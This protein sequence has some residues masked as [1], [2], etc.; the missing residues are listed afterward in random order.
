MQIS[1][2]D[3]PTATDL[4]ALENLLR[5]SVEHGASVGFILPVESPQIR[6]YWQGVANEV[7]DGSCVLLALIDEGMLAG[8]VQ[9]S[10]CMK[11]NG[12]HRAELQK[13]LV[14]SL[15][16]RRGFGRALMAAA[17]SAAKSAGRS[18]MVLDTESHRAGQRLYTSVGY[19]VVGEIPN[20]ALGTNGGFSPTTFMYKEI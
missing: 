20:Y 6:A 1:R 10:L 4:A 17:E 3:R 8:S 16:R 12:M 19:R 18:L 2:L 13:M 7:R 9:V 15:Y 14:H 5:D 11:P